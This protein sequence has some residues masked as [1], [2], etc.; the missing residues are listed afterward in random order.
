MDPRPVIR[1][2]DTV[3]TSTE[4]MKYSP[5]CAWVQALE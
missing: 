2:T 1:A 5:K 3:V 4:F